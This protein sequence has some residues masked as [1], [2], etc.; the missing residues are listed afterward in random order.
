MRRWE[1]VGSYWRVEQDHKKLTAESQLTE[2]LSTD[3]AKM[4]ESWSATFDAAHKWLNT[5]REGFKS[6]E[7]IADDD[8]KLM[9]V[10]DLLRKETKVFCLLF[11]G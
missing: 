2:G 7:R 8:K 1:V 3:T 5:A 10:I 4:R 9:K 6:S 11:T